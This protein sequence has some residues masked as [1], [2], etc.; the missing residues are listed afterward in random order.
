MDFK[1][2]FGPDTNGPSE[3][4]RIP[5]MISTKNNIVVACADARFCSGADNPNRI[6][7]VVRRSEDSGETWSDYIVAVEEKGTKQKSL[8]QPLTRF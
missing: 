3:F 1:T 4:Y 7:K 8:L 2:V 5:S 6:D